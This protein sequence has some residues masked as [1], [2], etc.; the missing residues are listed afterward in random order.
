MLGGIIF[1]FILF[2]VFIHSHSVADSGIYFFVVTNIWL[3]TFKGLYEG[4]GQSYWSM[5]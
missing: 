4:A 2:D 3:Q 1:Y 5:R